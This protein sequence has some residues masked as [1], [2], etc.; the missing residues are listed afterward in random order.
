MYA[1]IHFVGSSERNKSL[2]E[3]SLHAAV[4]IL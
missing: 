2:I 3:S 1:R 4:E